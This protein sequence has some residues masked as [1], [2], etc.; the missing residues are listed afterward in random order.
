MRCHPMSLGGASMP[1]R[2]IASAKGGQSAIDLFTIAF[3]DYAD[4][5][6]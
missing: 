3:L 2:I 5:C 1:T 4:L 6:R